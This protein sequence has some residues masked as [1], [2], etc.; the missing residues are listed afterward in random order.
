M[1]A[2]RQFH[3]PLKIQINIKMLHV[4]I[5][6]GRQEGVKRLNPVTGA[7]TKRS[8]HPNRFPLRARASKSREI[9]ECP[10]LLLN[11]YL[12]SP[13]SRR[14]SSGREHGH[15]P[16]KIAVPAGS[17]PPFSGKRNRIG[18]SRARNTIGQTRKDR[19]RGGASGRDLERRD[20]GREG[21]ALSGST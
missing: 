18:N 15:L 7:Y 10:P 12:S 16:S 14:S 2:K 13:V 3:S 6:G 17:Y 21:R 20:T 5:K 8:R 1:Q 4:Y 9:E 19:A 11:A